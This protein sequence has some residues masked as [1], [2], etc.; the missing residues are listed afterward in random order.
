M[1]KELK[2]RKELGRVIDTIWTFSGSRKAESFKILP[3]S[4]TDLIF[5]TN[6]NSAFVS[7]VMTHY[8]LQEL[9]PDSNLIGLRFKVEKL[10]LLSVVPLDELKNQQLEIK[11]VLPNCDL[12]LLEQ[13]NG[14]KSEQAKVQWVENFVQ[15]TIVARSIDQDEE[16]LSIVEKI[17]RAKGNISVHGLVNSTSLSHR[18]MERRFKKCIGLT[19]KQFA[20][21]VRFDFSKKS[22]SSG[23]DRSLQDIA[24]EYGYYDHAHMTHEYNRLAGENPSYFR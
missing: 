4:C 7:G 10:G 19:I 13:L 12:F 6:N 22:I 18:Q 17:R 21:I 8:Q 15:N 5:N 3:D 11:E 23:S 24:F 2:P 9:G 16:M 14:C 20:S 1:Y